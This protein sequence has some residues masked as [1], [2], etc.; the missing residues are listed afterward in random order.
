MKNFDEMMETLYHVSASTPEE[1]R[2]LE[3]TALMVNLRLDRK[4]TIEETV[5]FLQSEGISI[6][7]ETLIRLEEV[8][9]E[10]EDMRFLTEIVSHLSISK[11]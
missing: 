4:E 9:Y 6:D 7:A 11:P 10:Q 1:R 8:S 2:H 3:S 5:E